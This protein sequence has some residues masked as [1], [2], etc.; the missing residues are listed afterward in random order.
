MRQ[1][2]LNAVSA[3]LL[4]AVTLGSAGC[5]TAQEAKSAGDVA[6]AVPAVKPVPPVAPKAITIK[7]LEATEEEGKERTWLGVGLAEPDEA[8][9]S[10]LGLKD[11]AGLLVTY[12]AKESPAETAGLQK[13]DVLLEMEGQI[14]IV[15]G[16][17]QKL[18][19]G[20][21]EGDKVT[22]KFLRGGKNDSV[23]ATLGKTKTRVMSADGDNAF[24]WRTTPGAFAFAHA[25]EAAHADH[26]VV[27]EKALKDAKIDQ[28]RVKVEVKR[29]MEEARKAMQEALRTT[30]KADGSLNDLHRELEQLAKARVFM[31]NDATVVVRNTGK[32]SKS[33]VSTDDSGTIVLVKN[34]KLRLTV[35]D[36]DGKLLF[37][38][39]IESQ[40]QREKI[41]TDLLKK[42]EPMLEKFSSGDD[43]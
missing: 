20:R 12:V 28:E 8:L 9:I 41:P 38:G 42:V 14:L 6:V 26:M 34:P 22:L 10:Q 25:P 32:S 3:L 36:K 13:N 35:H 31:P 30:S 23:D 7:R 43:E 33:M 4:S 27:L 37:D 19:Q 16:Q 39:E 5:A 29:S 2:N 21:K 40:A 24:V 17:L 11:G 18:V 15:P 1:S